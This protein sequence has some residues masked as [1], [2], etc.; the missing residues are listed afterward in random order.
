MIANNLVITSLLNLK[1]LWLDKV[2]THIKYFATNKIWR[3]CQLKR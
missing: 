1:A 3:R 2:C